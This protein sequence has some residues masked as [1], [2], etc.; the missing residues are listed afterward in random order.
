MKQHVCVYVCVVSHAADASACSLSTLTRLNLYLVHEAFKCM[1]PQATSLYANLSCRR[2][3]CMQ[4]KSHSLASENASP[5]HYIHTHIGVCVCVCVCV[6]IYIYT[7]IYIYI[8]SI[9][10]FIRTTLRVSNSLCSKTMAHK[11]KLLR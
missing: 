2:C 11:R 3:Q 1:K 6:F 7:Y 10:K 8:S 5:R 4:P 9:R